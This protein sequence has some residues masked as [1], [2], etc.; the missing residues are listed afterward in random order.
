MDLSEFEVPPDARKEAGAPSNLVVVQGTVAI[1]I[2]PTQG[3][4]SLK[5]V[6]EG[7]QKRDQRRSYAAAAARP[8]YGRNIGTFISSNSRSSGLDLLKMDLSKVKDLVAEKWSLAGNC[9]IIPLVVTQHSIDDQAETQSNGDKNGQENNGEKDET[10]LSKNQRK[11]WRIKN[12][13]VVDTVTV[14]QNNSVEGGGET[15]PEAEKEATLSE[16]EVNTQSTQVIQANKDTE[17]V[18]NENDDTSI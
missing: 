3:N 2:A 14:A 9:M 17:N 8:K 15:I 12:K 18:V 4:T 6:V 11:R 13:A 10:V 16:K 1:A 7:R 5:E